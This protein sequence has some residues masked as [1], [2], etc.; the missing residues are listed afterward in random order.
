MAKLFGISHLAQI[1]VLGDFLGLEPKF[2]PHNKSKGW[3]LPKSWKWTLFPN[4]I[5]Q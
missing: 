2:E 5:G 3:K 4:Q 1:S